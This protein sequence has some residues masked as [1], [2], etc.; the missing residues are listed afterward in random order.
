MHSLY[1]EKGT[2]AANYDYN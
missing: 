1:N 2:K